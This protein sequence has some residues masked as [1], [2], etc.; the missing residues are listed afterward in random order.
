MLSVQCENPT[1]SSSAAAAA[2]LQPWVGLGLLLR[3]LY[4]IFLE[5]GVVSLT[6]NPQHGGPGYLFFVWV[7]TVDLSGMRGSTSNTRYCQ[8]S[9]WDHTTTQDPQLRQSRD[10]CEN[11]TERINML[12][13]KKQSLYVLQHV[14]HIIAS[15]LWKVKSVIS[16]HK[17]LGLKFGMFFISF[18][19]FYKVYSS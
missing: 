5:G 2:A 16:N 18:H 19:S 12:C 6:P 3:F 4:N 13:S 11:H 15:L 1:S 10:T 17:F 7:I 9:S 14:I 8:H